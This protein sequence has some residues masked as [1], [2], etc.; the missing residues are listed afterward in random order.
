MS[1]DEA[2]YQDWIASSV[3]LDMYWLRDRWVL[4]KDFAKSEMM[5]LSILTDFLFF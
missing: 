3:L 5:M 1:V 4:D 2:S